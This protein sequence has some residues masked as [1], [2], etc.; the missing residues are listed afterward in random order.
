MRSNRVQSLLI[1][2]QACVLYGAAEFSRDTDLALLASPANIERLQSA[3]DELKARPIA[4][5]PLSLDYLNRGHGVHFRCHSPEADGMRIDVM[6]VM[7]GVAPFEE[8]WARRTTVEIP[9]GPGIEAL[10]LPDLV[11]SKKTQRDKDWVMIKRLVEAH[12]AR[13]G[14]TADS[15]HT[16]FW[17]KESRTPEILLDVCRE[18]PELAATLAAHRPLLRSASAGDLSGLAAAL[19]AEEQVEREADRAYWLPLRRELER[20]RHAPKG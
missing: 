18:D 1:G 7:R 16:A 11:Q 5:P 15:A 19:A 9:D 12:Y 3:L 4:V 2:G 20:L 6:A 8:L 17:L 13:N 14:R 10:S